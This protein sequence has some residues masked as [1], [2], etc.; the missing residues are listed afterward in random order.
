MLKLFRKLVLAVA[1]IT[2]F[3]AFAITAYVIYRSQDGTAQ[4]ESLLLNGQ[5]RV[6]RAL[7]APDDPIKDTLIALIDNETKSIKVATYTFTEK[8]LAH[9]LL[10][11]QARG[12]MIEIVTDRN[13][14]AEKFSR[15]SQ[16]AD[17]HI[18]VWVF[19]TDP[20]DRNAG[21]MHNKFMIFQNTLFNRSILCTG[22]YNY[23]RRAGLAN[24]ENVIITDSPDLI[25]AFNRQFQTLKSRS[26]LISGR[27]GVPLV[28]TVP[29]LMVQKRPSLLNW[30][31]R[32]LFVR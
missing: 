14:A 2:V 8:D 18:P 4:L 11:A 21:L 13:Y 26:L 31:D 9:A 7:F 32:I 10:R 12:V 5:N 16:L 17:H 29:P 27:P 24:Q 6:E 3:G 30:I 22:S 28:P 25:D 20:D 15:V 1:F 19:Q 23:T